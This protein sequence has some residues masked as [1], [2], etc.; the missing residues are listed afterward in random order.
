MS[1]APT[2]DV[3]L[4]DRGG[5]DALSALVRESL[6]SGVERRAL[7]IRT[8]VLPPSLSRPIHLRRARAAIDPLTLADR[9]RC[10]ELPGGRLVV[11]WRGEA[12]KLLQETITALDHLLQEDPFEAP[13]INQLIGFY[14]LPQDGITL[15]H[16]A[17]KA[18]APALRAPEPPPEPVFERPV[19]LR[20]LDSLALARIEQS[21]A[22]ADL[23]RFARR[24]SVCHLSSQG[25]QLAWDDRALSVSELIADVAPGRDARSDPWLF[26]R[27]TRILDR[28]MLAIVSDSHELRDARPFCI[29]L[30]V[31]TVL[32][33]DFLRFDAALPSSLRNRVVISLLPADIAADASAFAFARNFARRR[34]YK[35]GLRAVTASL[36]PA[37]DLAALELDFVQL[38]W[39][40]D[41]HR[42]HA[43][44]DAGATRWIMGRP[45][46]NEAIEWG[47]TAGIGLYATKPTI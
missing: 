4:T 42:V 28:R 7:L 30:N 3:S 8:D 43:L 13:G 36:L 33:S 1:D 27:L 15:L 14:D 25:M 45:C 47:I 39:S 23:S 20:P 22:V 31:A 18:A 24:R 37:L 19:T 17:A 44:P 21:L 26:R 2:I 46:S 10:H 35:V 32:S 6:V 5:L 9:G 41:L 40:P 34:S 12:P 38:V 16:E 11:S 29:T